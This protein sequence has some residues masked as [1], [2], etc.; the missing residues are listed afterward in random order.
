MWCCAGARAWAR[1][2]LRDLGRVLV[3]DKWLGARAWARALLRDLGRVLVF[4]KWLAC[5]VHNIAYI[6]SSLPIYLHF[7]R[8]V[9]EVLLQPP[10]TVAAREVNSLFLKLINHFELLQCTGARD[11]ALLA[12]IAARS[13]PCTLATLSLKLAP[14]LWPLILTETFS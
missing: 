13:S 9:Y 14:S 6:R 11:Q 10:R 2:L 8:S 4:D 5:A 12:S 7:I 1:A 3:F